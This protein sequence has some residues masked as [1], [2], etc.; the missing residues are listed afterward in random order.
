MRHINAI[1]V[2]GSTGTL[3]SSARTFQLEK[4]ISTGNGRGNDNLIMG[5]I[6]TAF[7]VKPVF[8]QLKKTSLKMFFVCSNIIIF[9]N[10]NEIY[11]DFCI[12]FCE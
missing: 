12:F 7:M 9:P 11:P 6:S 3:P 2:Q 8:L 4:K 10:E 1:V 5:P